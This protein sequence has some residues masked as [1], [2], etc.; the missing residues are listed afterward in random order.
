[1]PKPLSSDYGDDNFDDLPSPSQ[2]LGNTGSNLTRAQ[3]PM[4]S[5]QV[6]A[7]NGA[8]PQCSSPMKQSRPS[9]PKTPPEIIEIPDD[10]PP[11]PTLGT[12]SPEPKLT[13]TEQSSL[14]SMNPEQP[15]PK[16]KASQDEASNSRR[17]KRNP[18]V[19]PFREKS[20]KSFKEITAV[21]EK[22]DIPMIRTWLDLNADWHDAD[23]DMVEEFKDIIDFI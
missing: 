9:T 10:T 21:P 22:T 1:M 15:H 7:S 5:T 3:S 19:S 11:P 16:R 8:V 6:K 23:I 13:T 18:F 14:P 12:P 4:S 17:F 2:L 20:P